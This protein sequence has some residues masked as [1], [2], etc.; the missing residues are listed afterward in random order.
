[1]LVQTD[2]QSDIELAS[3]FWGLIQPILTASICSYIV[4]YLLRIVR[5]KYNIRRR[6]NDIPQLPRHPILGSLVNC[7]EK[8]VGSRHPDYG[9]KRYGGSVGRPSCFLMDLSLVDG[10]FLILVEPQLAKAI[11][12]PSKRYKYSASKSDTLVDP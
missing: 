12:F 11:V 5:K 7:G 2:I 1:V 6:Y 4:L 9:L 3:T 8:L 10:A